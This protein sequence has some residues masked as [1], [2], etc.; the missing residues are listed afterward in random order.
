M[1][2]IEKRP[3]EV[4]N[5]IFE[6]SGYIERLQFFTNTIWLYLAFLG[7]FF[8]YQNLTVNFYA[9]GSNFAQFILEIVFSLI[10]I[11]ATMLYLANIKKRVTDIKGSVDWLYI[12]IAW[13]IAFVPIAKVLLIL[14]LSLI[15]SHKTQQISYHHA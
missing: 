13:I 3:L 12:G 1:K 6:F 14:V 7:L 11:Y 10:I 8:I 5:N 9:S 15:P 2:N 4:Q